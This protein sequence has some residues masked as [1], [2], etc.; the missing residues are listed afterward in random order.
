M[1]AREYA[2]WLGKECTQSVRKDFNNGLEDMQQILKEN[3]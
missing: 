2:E 3:G 1:S